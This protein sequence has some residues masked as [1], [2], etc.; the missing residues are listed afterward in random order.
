M[1]EPTKKKFRMWSENGKYYLKPSRFSKRQEISEE[2]FK[3]ILEKETITSIGIIQNQSL[4]LFE[5]FQHFHSHS[6]AQTSEFG[7]RIQVILLKEEQTESKEK[8]VDVAFKLD[9][10]DEATGATADDLF[11]IT[12][13]IEGVTGPLTDRGVYYPEVF[14]SLYQLAFNGYLATDDEV[15][16]VKAALK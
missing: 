13:T 12:S 6:E 5:L 1:V 9:M 16:T 7:R 10:L 8:G 15:A 14:R 2:T 3:E 4:G 11:T